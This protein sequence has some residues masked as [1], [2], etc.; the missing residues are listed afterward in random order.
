VSAA[1]PAAESATESAAELT[2]GSAAGRGWGTPEQDESVAAL[3][4]LAHDDWTDIC[5]L[6]GEVGRRYGRDIGVRDAAVAVGE[7]VGVL[8][9]HGVVPGDLRGAFEPWSGSRQER[10]DQVRREMIAMDGMPWPGQIA[11][12]FRENNSPAGTP[13]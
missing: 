1:E 9:D 12:F 2:A 5:A 3:I 11:W 13:R 6:T 8:I 4:E 7:L 10:V